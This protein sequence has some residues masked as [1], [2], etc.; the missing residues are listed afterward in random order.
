MVRGVFSTGGDVPLGGMSP[1]FAYH[2]EPESHSGAWRGPRASSIVAAIFR[3]GC[4]VCSSWCRVGY[5]VGVVCGSGVRMGGWYGS[6]RSDRLPRDWAAI[7]VMVRE[8]AHNRCQASVHSVLCN[9]IGDDC[10][11]IVPGDDHSLAN[12]QW[13]NHNCH[14]LKTA[15]ESAERNARRACQRR[16]PVEKNPGS[17]R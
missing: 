16:H 6:D 14:K 17:F 3:A 5:G 12:L 2:R 13:L 7:R 11:H 8:R 4:C 1:P 15:R 10:D 9:G